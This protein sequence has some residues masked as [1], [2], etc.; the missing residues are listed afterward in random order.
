MSIKAQ[1]SKVP[2]YDYSTHKNYIHK[3]YTPMAQVKQVSLLL[4]LLMPS[5]A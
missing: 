5:Y 2:S 4:E 1:V 3:P